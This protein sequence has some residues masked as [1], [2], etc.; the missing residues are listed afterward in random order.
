MSHSELLDLEAIVAPISD[1]H[2]CGTQR[3][4]GEDTV[5]SH[6][7]S[8]LNS[9]AAIA[10]K[11][12][13]K[14][15]ALSSYGPSD[16]QR[17]LSESQ[18]MSDGPQAD[19]KWERIV[20]LSIEILTKHSKDTRVMVFLIDGM[21]RCYGLKGMV[22]AFKANSMLLETYQLDLFPLP[23]SGESPDYCLEH[24]AKVCAS[25]TSNVRAAIF[26]SELFGETSGYS[27]SSYISATNLEKITGSERD[28]YIQAGDLTVQDFAGKL[29]E[30]NDH[31]V[32]T[33]FDEQVEIALAEAK[34]LDAWITKLSDRRL[35]ITNII[36]G[37]TN[38]LRWHRAFTEDRL[39]AIA[40]IPGENELEQDSSGGLAS[41]GS[42]LALNGAIASRDQA[43]SSLLQVAS[44]FRTTEPHSPLSYA[45]EQAVRWGKMPLPELLKDLV[46]DETVLNE[47]FRRMGIQQKD[48]NSDS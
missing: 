12:E 37:L 32:L 15:V 22:D 35:G 9:L 27:W 36:D 39:K 28:E 8:E 38:L 43:L 42:R 4:T 45:L 46:G 41:G 11:I 18:G 5:L 26:Q 24:I 47:V 34:K 21:T 29:A 3:E 2:P 14:R 44:F 48:D 7:F 40:P 19:P 33:Q 30:I 16:R 17:A 13:A 10:R 20:E 31:T 1:T 23:E 25:E 6:V